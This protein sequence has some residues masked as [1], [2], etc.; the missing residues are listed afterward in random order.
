MKDHAKRIV[1]HMLRF[2]HSFS[3]LQSNANIVNSTPNASIRIPE[4]TYKLKKVIDAQFL[5]EYHI[6]CG[7]CNTYSITKI[8]GRQIEC[9]SCLAGI[10]TA[11]SQFF[12]YIP[13]EEQLRKV[14]SDHFNE[15][16]LYPS[17][18]DGKITDVHDFL[19]YKKVE[20][21][22]VKSKVISLVAC[23][24]GVA[25]Y[26]SS[27]KSLWA[28]QLYLNCLK[29][30]W[31]YVPENILVVALH[32]G[33]HKPDM[34][35]FFF[36]LM[37]ELKQI[38]ESGGILVTKNHQS[39][40]FTPVITHGCFDLPAKAD[41]QEMMGHAGH[42]ACG[43]CFHP[44]VAVKKDTK[45]KSYV[46]YIDRGKDE[47][48]RTHEDMIETYSKL[49][50]SSRPINGVKRISCLVGATDF[51]LI[52]GF[53]IDY[54][55]C[56]LLGIM[57]K[58]LDLWLNST[59]HKQPYYISP[60]KQEELNKRIIQIKPIA[61]ITRRPR[62]L[63]ERAGYKANELRTLLLYYLRFCL[64]DLL[65]KSYIDHFH[66]LSSATYMLLKESISKEEIDLAEKR[67]IQFSNE[68]QKLYGNH[69]VTLNIHLVKHMGSQ[70][71]HLGPFW[72]QSAF[73]M[74]A[75]NGVLN[76]ITA[77]KSVVH[78][79]AWK[80]C[81][82]RAQTKKKRDDD[83]K[84]IIGEKSALL[85][86]RDEF[87]VL[88]PFS[89]EMKQTIYKNVTISGQKYTSLKSKQIATV[90]YFVRLTEGTVGMIKFYFIHDLIIYGLLE[91]YEIIEKVDQFYIVKSSSII[92]VFKAS[93]I[94]TKMIYMKIGR[95]E[96][97]TEVPNRF[98]KT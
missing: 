25:L 2:N 8:S 64:P 23:A 18:E 12:A 83:P 49:K 10:S 56:I 84:F 69:N 96:I 40:R 91:K 94:K 47:K 80:Y 44:G 92:E 19:Q 65:K 76:K 58:L 93:N 77:R 62:P 3:S 50:S 21:K 66:L 61:A 98:E 89:N 9:T 43:F 71:R 55:H 90:D 34:Q 54:M 37:T 81:A 38:I 70:V 60:K 78:S 15:I 31:R 79:I 7:T 22:Y 74:E 17:S 59:N 32:V 57:D 5:V 67:L 42:F 4:T 85:M 46:R 39:M 29:P 88:S 53:S 36:P 87:N 24:D 45:S 6:R 97:I 48:L 41:I 86:T 13:L 27:K 95:N 63:S 16:C 20:E 1:S 72:A 26:N 73:G 51:D 30:T 35:D 82:S 33:D 75:T 11:N 68:F 52:H 14:I 28:I